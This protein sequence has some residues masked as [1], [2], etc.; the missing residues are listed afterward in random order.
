MKVLHRFVRNQ[1]LKQLLLLSRRCSYLLNGFMAFT[2][3]P[4]PCRLSAEGPAVPLTVRCFKSGSSSSREPLSGSAV[5]ELFRFRITRN[6]KGQDKKGMPA[7]SR[8][9]AGWVMETEPLRTALRPHTA[10][11][12]ASWDPQRAANLPQPITAE[13]QHH[14]LRYAASTAAEEPRKNDFQNKSS[15]WCLQGNVVN[16]TA[17]R[18][19]NT[20]EKEQQTAL[21]NRQK[22]D[23]I[24]ICY[25]ILVKCI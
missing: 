17:L 9:L 4:G 12:A 13:K 20:K 10:S 11:T 24:G 3:A 2:S 14:V 7:G 23:K 18:F 6:V 16:A 15:A 1:T 25:I 5:G 8:P 21:Q 22:S 19:L